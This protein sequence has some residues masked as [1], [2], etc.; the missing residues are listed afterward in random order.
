MGFFRRLFGGGARAAADKALHLYIRCQRCGTPVHVRVDLERDLAADYGDTAAEG[1]EFNKD[2]MDDRCFRM[3]RAHLTFD[4][5]RNELSRAIEGG[6]FI[7]EE[8]YAAFQAE[9]TRA[10]R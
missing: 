3:M 10:A 5:H 8:E 9:R 1:Y 6:T 4:A 7:T 2:V